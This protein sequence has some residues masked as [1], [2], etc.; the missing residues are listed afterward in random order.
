MGLKFQIEVDGGLN[1]EIALKLKEL[2]VD[3]AV[4]GDYFL[5][6]KKRIFIF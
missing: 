3:I 2:G 6:I 1:Y 5:K 4:F